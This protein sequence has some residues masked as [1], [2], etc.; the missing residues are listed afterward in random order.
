M[1]FLDTNVLVYAYDEGH[2]EKQRIAVACVRNAILGSGTV[3]AQ[4]LAEFSAV[5]L[6]KRVRNAAQVQRI[7]DSL[8]PITAISTDAGLIRRALDACIEY[9]LHL[10]DAL[11]VAAAERAG[12]KRL[13]TEDLSHGQLYFGIVAH[14][15]FRAENTQL[16]QSASL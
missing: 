9:G 8:A 3:S 1:D 14:N 12:A 16:Q 5:L 4:V 15:P 13:L 2:P 11:I 6:R 7:F 10:Y